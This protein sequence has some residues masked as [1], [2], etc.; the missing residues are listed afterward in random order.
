MAGQGSRLQPCHPNGCLAAS[1]CARRHCDAWPTP[2]AQPCLCWPACS[3]HQ[4]FCC[5]SSRISL[6]AGLLADPNSPTAAAHGCRRCGDLAFDGGDNP[7][8]LPRLVS[9]E[10]DECYFPPDGFP[11]ALCLTHL[12]SLRLVGGRCTRLPPGIS[13][14]QSLQVGTGRG[15]G[16]RGLP[17]AGSCLQLGAA[18]RPPHSNETFTSASASFSSVLRTRR[19]HCCCQTFP[20]HRSH[21]ACHTWHKSDCCSPGIPPPTA[22]AGHRFVPAACHPT[23][24]QLPHLGD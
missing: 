6:A 3:T 21:L 11:L 2:R 13:Q 9:L 24:H 10:I 12:T 22:G 18:C 17:A 20:H 23:L 19:P 14:L 1:C 15:G 5:P 8:D 7:V 4:L 16:W